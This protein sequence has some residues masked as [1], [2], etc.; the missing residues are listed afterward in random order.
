[1]FSFT[2]CAGEFKGVLAGVFSS[3][4]LRWQ[5]SA[6]FF[7][8]LR[9]VASRQRFRWF[10]TALSLLFV[11]SCFLLH[12]CLSRYLYSSYLSESDFSFSRYRRCRSAP[13]SFDFLPVVDLLLGTLSLL[14]CCLH[15][16]CALDYSS[17]HR[18]LFSG[19]TRNRVRNWL[20]VAFLL[21]SLASFLEGSQSS[22]SCHGSP[23][24][25]PVWCFQVQLPG[26]PLR[27]TP[28]HKS[29]FSSDMSSDCE[30]LLDLGLGQGTAISNEVVF[31]PQLC[32]PLIGLVGSITCK[33]TLQN[34]CL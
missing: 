21:F 19:I 28:K 15:C 23:D 5:R 25:F 11:L 26:G 30:S 1:M 33:C 17:I 2:E 27:L 16:S 6:A 4:I 12:R 24:L 22:S 31:S 29:A 3:S 10:L 13:D 34:V 9:C 7:S 18:R 20:S 14:T 8:R 32:T